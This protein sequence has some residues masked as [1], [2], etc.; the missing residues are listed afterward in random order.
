[1]H[2]FQSKQYNIKFKSLFITSDVLNQID[3]IIQQHKQFL[4]FQFPFFIFRICL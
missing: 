3:H 1:M 2:A 4:N